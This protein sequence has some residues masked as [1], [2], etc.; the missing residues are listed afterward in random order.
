MAWL[1]T[2]TCKA[3]EQVLER[4]GVA[5]IK[6]ERENVVVVNI[7]RKVICKDPAQVERKTEN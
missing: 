5:E 2:E 1:T 4:N 7:G 3:I 6:R